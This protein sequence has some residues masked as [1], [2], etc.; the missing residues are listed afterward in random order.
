MIF[1]VILQVFVAVFFVFGLYSALYQ[2][3]L[4]AL[5]HR[6]YGEYKPVCV[7]FFEK[8]QCK[9]GETMKTVIKNTLDDAQRCGFFRRGVVV[10][11]EEEIELP[12][13]P[14]VFYTDSTADYFSRERKVPN[15][16]GTD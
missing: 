8:A 12:P 4:P 2:L 1:T 16:T 3:L 9:D 7:L 11:T 13:I 5:K 15:G 6:I 10:F 14:D